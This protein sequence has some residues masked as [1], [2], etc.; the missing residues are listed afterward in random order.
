MKMRRTD[1]KA[2]SLHVILTLVICVLFGGTVYAEDGEDQGKKM[3]AETEL[4]L[5]KVFQKLEKKKITDTNPDEKN[6][7]RKDTVGRYTKNKDYRQALKWADQF[8]VAGQIA[9]TSTP[10]RPSVTDV[11]AHM[12]RYEWEESLCSMPYVFQILHSYNQQLDLYFEKDD[13]KLQKIAK[14][15]G[16]IEN[17]FSDI[18]DPKGGHHVFSKHKTQENTKWEKLIDAALKHNSVWCKEG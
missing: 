18:S 16:K 17:Y 8:E 12:N 1:Q 11:I 9:F 10:E 2:T 14:M 4:A 7:N 13:A 15:I 3:R 5:M 6:R